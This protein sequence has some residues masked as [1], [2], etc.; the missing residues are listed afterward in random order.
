[1][2]YN[3]NFIGRGWSFPPSFDPV[4][5]SVAM[6]EEAEDIEQSIEIL[7]STS[8]KERVMRPE[9]GCNMKDHQ[10]A[11]V[12]N[13]LIYELE[14]VIKRAILYFEPRIDL[15]NITITQPGDYSLIEGKL[16]IDLEYTIRTINSRYNY[17][18]DYYLREANQPIELDV[19]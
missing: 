8:F 10:F 13:S 17:V 11:P 9:F 18:F 7:L 15:R 1:M 19:Y 12:N 16:R 6:V 2:E 14:H 4:T 5:G 3:N